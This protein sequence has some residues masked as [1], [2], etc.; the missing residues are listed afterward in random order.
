MAALFDNLIKNINKSNLYVSL[1]EINEKKEVKSLVNIGKMELLNDDTEY[2][3]FFTE[4]TPLE[5]EKILKNESGI[6]FLVRRSSS[7]VSSNP[8]LTLITISMN[9]N[10]NYVNTRFW[11]DKTFKKYSS[12]ETGKE[13]INFKE[14]IDFY[15]TNHKNLG[16]SNNQLKGDAINIKK[17]NDKQKQQVYNTR[18]ISRED[19]VKNFNKA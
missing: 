16:S 1:D 8:N 2:I 11:Y 18:Y 6:S 7:F 17:L 13:F 5:C 14:I 12:Y 9:I 15:V 3:E 4:L 10:N 19:A